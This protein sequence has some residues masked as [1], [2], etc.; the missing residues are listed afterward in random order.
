[1]HVRSRVDKRGSG[2]SAA[3]T[4]I[5]RAL[6]RAC[7]MDR[8]R[9]SAPALVHR[10]PGIAIG[11]G[12]DFSLPRSTVPSYKP[13]PVDGVCLSAEVTGAYGFD[14]RGSDVQPYYD[15]EQRHRP[16]EV[17][18]KIGYGAEPIRLAW[19]PFPE[20]VDVNY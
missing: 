10:R 11:N 13:R 2:I 9:S 8:T 18:R 12:K 6:L 14:R 3:A 1:M 4:R 16:V 5:A 17:R 15:R 19:Q 20:T 7:L